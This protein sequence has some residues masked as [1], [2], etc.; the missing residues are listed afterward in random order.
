M[1]KIKNAGL[2]GELRQLLNEADS[3]EEISGGTT[4]PTVTVPIVEY[5]IASYILGNKGYVCSWTVEC[6]AQCK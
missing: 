4:V 3:I 6:Q 2:E 5:T 1:E